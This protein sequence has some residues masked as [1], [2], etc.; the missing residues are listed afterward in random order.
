MPELQRRGRY[1]TSY[2]DSTLRERLLDPGVHRLP[3]THPGPPTAGVD[4]QRL[5]GRATGA[6]RGR[7]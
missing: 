4:G 3:A 2:E 5:M 6:R 7:R 1:R